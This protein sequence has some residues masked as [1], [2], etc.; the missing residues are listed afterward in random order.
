MNDDDNI[1]TVF[2]TQAYRA[3]ELEPLDQEI[4]Q[5]ITQLSRPYSPT[6]GN[7]DRRGEELEREKKKERLDMVKRKRQPLM[8]L[9]D[10]F[11][12]GILAY[13]VRVFSRE[14]L[15]LALMALGASDPHRKGSCLGP[16]G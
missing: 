11:S 2:A 3:P 12:F 15:S 7:I 5:T 9:A 1:P 4:T 6:T 8:E 13:L 16:P 10:V 14:L